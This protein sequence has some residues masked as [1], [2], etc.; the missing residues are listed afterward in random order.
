MSRKSELKERQLETALEAGQRWQAT[1]DERI[2]VEKALAAGGSAAADKPA[3]VEAFRKRED[4]RSMKITYARIGGGFERA[5][6]PLNWAN[7]P[8]DELAAAAGK[9]VARIVEIPQN[10][11]LEPEGFGTGFLVSP[12]LLLTNYHVLASASEAKG[13]GANF[14]YEYARTGGITRG[15]VFELDP[16]AFF[17]SYKEL[18]LALVA[19]KTRSRAG[20]A[21]DSFGNTRLIAAEGKILEGQPVNIIQYPEGGPKRYATTENKLLKLLETGYLQYTTDTLRGSSG[22]PVFN[23]SWEAVGLHHSSVPMV[24]DGNIL[25]KKG[26]V[27]DEEKMS[28]DD[29]QWVANEGI[30]VTRIVNHLKNLDLKDAAKTAL[31]RELLQLTGDP[32]TEEANPTRPTVNLSTS[33]LKQ[34]QEIMGN[35]SITINGS[36]TINIYTTA[37]VPAQTTAAISSPGQLAIKGVEEARIR[38][39]EDYDNRE[40]YNSRFLTG[41]NIP[42]PTV[43]PQR[44]D[45]LLEGENGKPLVIPY[46]HFSLVMNKERR[47]QMWS[48]VNVDYSEGRRDERGRTAFGSDYWRSDPRISAEIQIE[49]KEFY[50]PAGKVDRGHIVRRDDNAWGDSPEEIEYANSDTFHW[51]NCTPQHER[52]NQEKLQGIWGKLESHVTREIEAADKRAIIFAGPVLDPNDPEIDFGDGSI[53]YPLRF[54]KVIVGVSSKA[55][56]TLE[57]YGF[58]L[59]QTDVVDEFGLEKMDFG[60]FKK[61]QKSLKVITKMTGVVFPKIV[62][63][64]DVLGSSA[65]DGDEDFREGAE[66]SG[67]I[68]IS[69]LSDIKIH[70]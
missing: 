69:R 57:A 64:A 10:A 5:I 31:L 34:G 66:R 13:I 20:V 30:R 55:N 65:P 61:E 41:F 62:L 50:K 68:N 18:D 22:S 29:I 39:D 59:D 45:E 6:G 25:T 8:P 43:T 19:V 17:Y 11:E 26:E 33:T 60:E 51:T 48:A 14:Q 46:H 7:S 47:L 24:K 9:P 32:L 53:Q 63:D 3:R 36:A 44:E 35:I 4:L 27:W 23:I 28:D 42:L 58:V 67:G 38:F 16:D 1:A 56:K 37:S 52:F 2:E 49:D 70:K 15:Q 12:R 54:W 21:L 40:G